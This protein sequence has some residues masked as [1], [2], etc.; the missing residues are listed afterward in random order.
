MFSICFLLSNFIII[1]LNII[2]YKSII[3]SVYTKKKIN[4]IIIL[5]NI[6]L[7]IIKNKNFKIMKCL[8]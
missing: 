6:L 1:L 7:L 2:Y 4:F 8:Q 3:Y 5:L